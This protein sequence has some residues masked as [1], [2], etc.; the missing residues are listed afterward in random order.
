M[1]HAYVKNVIHVV[2]STKDRGKT[3]PNKLQ[4]RLF[5]FVAGIC[6]NHG[7]FSYAIGGTGDH[8]H[9]LIEVPADMPVAKAVG[10]I[11]SNSSRWA[12]KNVP[13]FAWQ[14]GYAAFSVSA[15]VIPAVV[16]YIENQEAHHRKMSFEDEFVAMLKK[17]GVAFEPKFVFG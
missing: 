17:H 14:Q 16:R 1:P 12:N 8:V 4:S 15:S 10:T 7:I 6:R 9:L 5:A 11:K 13:T 3:I 2:F